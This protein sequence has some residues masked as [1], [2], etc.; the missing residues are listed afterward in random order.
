MEKPGYSMTKPNVHNMF[1]TNPARQRIING[2]LQNKERNYTLEE[3]ES[4]LSTNLK[5]GSHTNIIPPLITKND[6]KQQSLF[7][8][9]S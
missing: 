9:I 5:E 7:L 3:E 4:N 6:S 2:K 8:N 1:S